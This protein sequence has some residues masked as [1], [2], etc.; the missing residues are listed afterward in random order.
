MD[1][2]LLEQV[3]CNLCQSDVIQPWASKDGFKIVKCEKCGLVYVNP[4]LNKQGLVAAY[5]PEY[6]ALHSSEKLRQQREIMYRLDIQELESVRR[7]GRILDVGCGGGFLLWAMRSR[8]EKYGIELSETAAEHG[9]REFGLNIV[10]GRLTEGGFA[11]DFFDVVNF[12]GVIEHMPDPLADVKE[13]YR[14]L[15]KGGVIA[16]STPNIDSM[17]AKVFKGNFRLVDPKHHIY[18][19]STRT[20][21]KMLEKAGFVVLKISYPYFGT[22]YANWRDPFTFLWRGIQ[23]RILGHANVLS[24]PF[25]RNVVNMFAEK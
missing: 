14:I 8:W 4:R 20:L 19:F 2:H 24:P 10:S 16:I 3:N 23:L 1:A 9:R 17:C 12:R 25:W 7:S 6:F 5:G 11:D 18:Y 22:P 21:K 13:A 15:K